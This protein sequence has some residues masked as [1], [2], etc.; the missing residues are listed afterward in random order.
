VLCAPIGSEPPC[1]VLY[2]QR[3]AQPRPFR[4]EDRALIETVARN[5]ARQADRLLA[6]EALR[7]AGDATR[8]IRERL[9]LDGV[10]KKSETLA[11][12]LGEVAMVAPLDVSVLLTGDSGTGKSQLAWVIH[13]NSP[14][15]RRPL[16]EI[17]CATIPESLIE[18][19]LF[20]ALPGA[21]S[22]ARTRMEGKVAAAEGGTLFLDEVGELP[23]GVQAKLL[24]PLQSRIYYPLGSPRPLRADVRI[25][26]ATNSDLSEAV[27]QRRFREDLFY[28]LRVMPLR[29]PTLAERREDIPELARHFATKVA[30][31][32]GLP[33]L[34]LSVNAT[35][36]LVAA[37]WPGNVRQLENGIEAG[38]IR[39]ASRGASQLELAHLFPHP[40]RGEPS[41]NEEGLTFQEA[42]RRFQ[43]ALLRTTL[44]A[45]DGNVIEAARRLDLARSHVY[46]LIRVFG[47]GKKR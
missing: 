10:V 30:S 22:T 16:V 43:A 33:H 41:A 4:E 20:G 27:Q 29:M 37:E 17:N 32:H 5:L 46:N 42:T 35:K 14:R 25:I 24:Q 23:L 28:R 38:L 18:S 2:L 13:N 11:A 7:A 6:R 40:H 39:A 3:R 31:R 21:H 44:E 8:S 9:R 36:A 12:V 19:E 1:G 34:P 47:L 26:A 45:S 15:A